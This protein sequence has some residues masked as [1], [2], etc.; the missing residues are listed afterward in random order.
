MTSLGSLL[1]GT[2]GRLAAKRVEAAAA[3]PEAAQLRVLREIVTRNHDTEF[4]REHR[5]GEIDGLAAWRKSVPVATYEDLRPS[6]D[7]M[8]RGER[9]VLTAEAP[10]MFARTSGT[11]GSPKLIPVTP[12]CRRRAHADASR[13]FLWYALHDHPTILDG[14]AMSL[15]SPAVEGK[16]EAGIPFGSTSGAMYRGYPGPVQRSYAVPYEAFEI[17][18]YDAEYYVLQRVALGCDVTFLCTPNPTSIL[19]LCETADENAEDMLRDVHDGTLRSDLDIPR[20]IREAV[21]ARCPADPERAKLLRKARARRGGRLLPCDYW[22]NLA[23]ISCWKG[24]TVGFHLRRIGEWFDPG[25]SAPVP[26]R[27]LGWLA[28]EVRGSVPVSDDGLAGVPTI[29]RNLFEFVETDEVEAGDDASRWTFRSPHELEEGREY[30]AFVTTTGGLYRYDM[31]DVVRAEGR[32]GA[33]PR[34]VFV[35]KGRDVTSLTGEKLTA[36]Q[37]VE[38]CEGASTE[39]KVPLVHFA[40]EADVEKSRY[41]FL[42]EPERRVPERSRRALLAAIE[43]RLSELNIEYLAK[44]KSR[45]LRKPELRVM[46]RGWYERVRRGAAEKGRPLFQQKDLVLTTREPGKDGASTKRTKREAAASTE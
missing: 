6:I 45:R 10:E 43:R 2:V 46:K 41:T 39:A 38:A 32:F 27:D 14:K 12:A 13:A 40:A 31:N 29:G 21:L 24:G 17:E 30:Y 8:A 5:F 16:T 28:S 1:I 33:T 20:E 15:V 9:G 3:D 34:L 19:R 42:V 4:G 26:I 22:P 44:R 18:D 25:G 7:R 11:T 23:L 36:D 37:V 35:R